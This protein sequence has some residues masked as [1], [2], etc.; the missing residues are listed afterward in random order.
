MLQNEA[1]GKSFGPGGGLHSRE[2]AY[3]LLTQQ[4]W[5]QFLAFPRIFLLMLFRFI[6]SA[7]LNKGQRFDNVNRFDLVLA[8]GK[9]VLQRKIGPSRNFFSFQFSFHLSP[10]WLGWLASADEI[11]D[12]MRE[13]ARCY[14]VEKDIRSDPSLISF[15]FKKC[16]H[17]SC[18]CCTRV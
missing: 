17:L 16:S 11:L 18:C 7:A 3:L 5:V 1:A 8:S 4:P 13:V 6:D 2:V 9:L 15:C 12:Y 14:N 10:N